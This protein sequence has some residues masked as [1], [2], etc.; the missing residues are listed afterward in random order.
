[1][2]LQQ[3]YLSYKSNTLEG[4]GHVCWPRKRSNFNG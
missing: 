2:T 3:K 1:V 4:V